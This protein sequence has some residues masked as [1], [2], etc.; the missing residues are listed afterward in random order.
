[1]S[2]RWGFALGLA[3]LLLLGVSVQAAPGDAAFSRDALGYLRAGVVAGDTLY[4]LGDE[5]LY[6][7]RQGDSAP[8]RLLDAQARAGGMP[9]LLCSDGASLWGITA[10]G[11][12][13]H[14]DGTAFQWDVQLQW[15]DMRDAGGARGLRD[16]VMLNGTLYALLPPLTGDNGAASLNGYALVGYNTQSG[17]CKTLPAQFVWQIAPYKESKL[18]LLSQ[19]VAAYDGAGGVLVYD[20]IA[21]RVEQTLATLEGFSLGGLAYDAASDTAYA[22]SGGVLHALAPGEPPAAVA[23]LAARSLWDDGFCGLLPGG[24]YVSGDALS[25]VLV[26][27]I[28]PQYMTG[29]PL[30]IRGFNA[31][32]ALLEAFQRAHP[33]MPVIF[34][35]A[36]DADPLALANRMT[37]GD[38]SFDVL[39]LWMSAGLRALMRRGYLADVTDVPGIADAV[40]AMYP[41]FQDALTWQGRVYAYPADIS[42][43]VWAV[44]DAALAQFGMEA[45]RTQAE[46]IALLARWEE[47][48]AADFSEYRFT[49]LTEG[50]EKEQLAMA[51]L[52]QYLL[53]YSQP[54]QPPPRLDTPV[55]RE[56]L[57][58]IAALPY[59][60]PDPAREKPLVTVTTSSGRQPHVLVNQYADALNRWGNYGA[61]GER[62]PARLML[63]PPFEAGQESLASVSLE[64][65]A[66][67]PR[68]PAPEQ[69]AAFLAFV[70]AHNNP[71]M[72]AMVN[73][74]ANEGQR[75]PWYAETRARVQGNFNDLNQRLRT[76]AQADKQSLQDSIREHEAYL[77]WLDTEGWAAAPHNIA[78]YRMLAS[79][80]RV[81]ADGAMGGSAQGW[82]ELETALLRYLAGQSGLDE[83][84]REM[85]NKLR[86]MYLEGDAL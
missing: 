36:V 62:I 60:R 34:L 43:S 1:M 73:P 38:D 24:Y 5:S 12:L 32:E 27:N 54:G 33:D 64:A 50:E 48:Y 85:D 35:E 2:K 78:A 18:L 65:F 40:A 41:Q 44:D 57:A 21:Q 23:Y 6:A 49:Y 30:R 29:T 55:L 71:A 52:S 42:V 68:S 67:N 56:V 37:Y 28:D 63:P 3:V 81:E 46:Y 8:A 76:A 74:N 16:P 83:T 69:A 53:L 47:E 19:N 17:A 15:D 58:G 10:D 39:Q 61:E 79:Q 72:H 75:E 20:P 14:W 31:D 51:T 9:S 45:P 11:M 13:G 4:L 77:A 26:R 7:Y 82:A 22:L 66:V 86:M 59:Q 84:L 80:L 25:G 70:A